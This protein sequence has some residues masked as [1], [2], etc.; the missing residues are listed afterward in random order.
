MHHM[1]LALSRGAFMSA[2]AF[3]CVN[4]GFGLE[5]KDKRTELLLS[6]EADQKQLSPPTVDFVVRPFTQWCFSCESAVL[7]S[8]DGREP[9]VVD[10]SVCVGGRRQEER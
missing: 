10:G 3:L 4:I 9:G 6:Q 8:V 5:T 7:L 1:S 2:G